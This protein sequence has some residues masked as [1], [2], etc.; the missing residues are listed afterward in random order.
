MPPSLYSQEVIMKGI[1]Y[2]KLDNRTP[3]HRHIPSGCK[4][5]YV[6]GWKEVEEIEKNEPIKFLK[7]DEWEEY[8]ESKYFCTS[9]KTGKLPL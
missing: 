1:N 2:E 7:W 5:I 4:R 8:Y 9:T 6:S 3:N